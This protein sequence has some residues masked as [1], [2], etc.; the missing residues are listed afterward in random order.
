MTW[1]HLQML[2]TDPCEPEMCSTARKMCLKS[3]ECKP[4]L[5]DWERHCM[6]VWES[7]TDMCSD[8]CNNATRHLYQDQYGKHFKWCD[9]GIH[10][11]GYFG[12]IKATEE[13]ALSRQ[14]LKRQYQMQSLCGEENVNQ[15]LKCKAEKG[16]Y[17]DV[18]KVMTIDIISLLVCQHSCGEITSYCTNNTGCVM[19]WE[20]YRNAC[21]EIIAW[22]GVTV[23]PTCSSQ[24]K[25]WIDELGNNLIGKYLK[26]CSCNEQDESKKEECIMERQKVGIAC[27]I[28]YNSITHCQQN[29]VLCSNDM[30]EHLRK[31][32]SRILSSLKMTKQGWYLGDEFVVPL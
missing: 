11:G 3:T 12:V 7:S 32:E 19:A 29:E 16:I 22:D 31:N 25:R 26:C 4:L 2:Y 18:H 6:S 24:C 30:L 1:C 27:D 13:L 21:K 20:N 10:S 8:E 23:M 15:C 28:D 14:C 5:E 9:C 17:S